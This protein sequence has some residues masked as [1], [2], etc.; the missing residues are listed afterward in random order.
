MIQITDKKIIQFYND[1]PTLDIVSMNHLFIDIIKQ[2]STNFSENMTATIN[3]QIL[4]TVND[5]K[6]DIQNIHSSTLSKLYD[7]K[8]EYVEDIKLLLS[9]N[10]LTSF[11]KIQH[12]I[13]KNADTLF[14]KTN[15]L[16]GDILP[17]Y[18]EKQYSSIENCVKTHFDMIIQ[19]TSQLLKQGG[20]ED[21]Q[22]SIANIETG[23]NN[24]IQNIISIV[25]TSEQ[26]TSFSVQQLNE[27]ISAQKQMQETLTTELNMF[28]NKYKN[29]SSVKGNISEIELYYMLQKI[30]PCDEIIR[31]SS[32]T[33]SCDIKLKRKLT[34]L[35]TILF[36]SKDYMSSVNSEEVNKFERDLQLQKCHGIFIS[37]NSPITFK[38]NFHIDIIHGIIHLYISNVQY[39]IEKLRVAINIVDHLSARLK[40]NSDDNTKG[41]SFT[42]EEADALKDEYMKFAIRKNE[43]IDCIKTFTKQMLEKMED[44]KLPVFKKMVL[45]GAGDNEGILCDICRNYWNKSAAGIAAHKRKCA[46]IH[47]TEPDNSLI[48]GG[49]KK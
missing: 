6:S 48:S 11:D 12:S 40:E 35:P 30:T 36:E 44:I 22:S 1:N 19:T 24:M 8:K 47:F 14:A 29:N 23:F 20:G 37:Q 32:E 9:N 2:L 39:D 13:E 26:R 16:L 45:N 27:K 34:H 18:G 15:A 38:E 17:K 42:Q 46:K 5:I 28:L 25:Q 41:L 10:E 43:M 7:I 4:N 31:C 3:Q 33:A 21:K 49:N